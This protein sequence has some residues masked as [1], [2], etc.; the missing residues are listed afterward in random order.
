MNDLEYVVERLK[1]SNKAAVAKAVQLSPRTVRDIA[2]GRQ[3][4]PS[5]ETIRRLTEHFRGKVS[6]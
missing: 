5:F 3:K 1:T 4:Q 6:Q 2:T